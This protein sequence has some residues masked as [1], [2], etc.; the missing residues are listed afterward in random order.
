MVTEKHDL[1][2]LQCQQLY[3]K[4]ERCPRRLLC[5]HT[6][7]TS[8]LAHLIATQSCK[9]PTCSRPFLARTETQLP[10]DFTIYKRLSFSNNENVTAQLAPIRGIRN[11]EQLDSMSPKD[12]ETNDIPPHVNQKK[13]SGYS[14]AESDQSD[15]KS[16]SNL[17]SPKPF[18]HQLPLIGNTPSTDRSFKNTE[19]FAA[20]DVVDV[21]RQVIPA[22][23]ITQQDIQSIP[24][25]SPVMRPLTP[26]V[27]PRSFTSTLNSHEAQQL[28]KTKLSHYH[29]AK[30][31]T[32][33][34]LHEIPETSTMTSTP[35]PKFRSIEQIRKDLQDNKHRFPQNIPK[36]MKRSSITSESL[37]EP[38]NARAKP[39]MK[40]YARGM[41]L[42]EHS[43]ENESKGI[44]SHQNTYGTD[45]PD[46]AKLPDATKSK[47]HKDKVQQA[48]DSTL[49]KF[50]SNSNLT[51]V[52]S[53]SD[54]TVNK[55][56]PGIP[57]DQEHTN[58]STIPDHINGKYERP[59]ESKSASPSL[60]SG[61]GSLAGGEGKYSASLKPMSTS[62]PLYT[63]S[64]VTRHESLQ[65]T[66]GEQMTKKGLLKRQAP[67]PGVNGMGTPHSTP[68]SIKDKE[69]PS[70]TPKEANMYYYLQ[71]KSKRKAPSPYQDASGRQT[72]PPLA[73]K[74]QNS[75]PKLQSPVISAGIN[76]S[77]TKR[78]APVPD[79]LRIGEQKV[80][81]AMQTSLQSEVPKFLNHLSTLSNIQ[82][83]DVKK[84]Q[85]QYERRPPTPP[86]PSDMPASSSEDHSERKMNDISSTTAINSNIVENQ[87]KTSTQPVSDTHVEFKKGNG[88]EN[89]L[90]CK[91]EEKQNSVARIEG[92]Y[93]KEGHKNLYPSILTKECS[94]SPTHFTANSPVKGEKN[95]VD[96]MES[97]RALYLSKIHSG[98]LQIGSVSS[99]EDRPSEDL[100]REEP[101]VK[102]HEHLMKKHPKKENAEQNDC[103][104]GVIKSTVSVTEGHVSNRDTR[105]SR[106][107]NRSLAMPQSEAK[108][109]VKPPNSDTQSSKDSDSNMAADTKANEN[110]SQLQKS[111]TKGRYKSPYL[112]E[113]TSFRNQETLMTMPLSKSNDSY[114][115]EKKSTTDEDDNE[116]AQGSRRDYLNEPTLQ[117][118]TGNPNPKTL[119]ADNKAHKEKSE[120]SKI[121]ISDKNSNSNIPSEGSPAK[122]NEYS[123]YV[124]RKQANICIA[125]VLRHEHSVLSSDESV[126]DI[127]TEQESFSKLKH[128]T[129]DKKATLGKPQDNNPTAKYSYGNESCVPLIK[130]KQILVKSKNKDN[131]EVSSSECI[132]KYGYHKES[133]IPLIR[134]DPIKKD[135][136]SK[137]KN[138]QRENREKL[139]SK[140][141][142]KRERTN[143]LNP[144]SSQHKGRLTSHYKEQ[145]PSISENSEE[146][147]TD[148]T[149]SVSETESGDL[150]GSEK[151]CIQEYERK[152]EM[153]QGKSKSYPKVN[154][155]T[156]TSKIMKSFNYGN[157]IKGFKS[158]RAEAQVGKPKTKCKHTSDDRDV[159]DNGRKHRRAKTDTVFRKSRMT[160]QEM[161]C[162]T[163][164]EYEG[165]SQS[166][167]EVSPKIFRHKTSRISR[168]KS[169]DELLASRKDY[170]TEKSA[171][172]KLR[173]K[174]SVPRERKDSGGSKSSYY[175]EKKHKKMSPA[176]KS[177]ECSESESSDIDAKLQRARQRV[178]DAMN[179][180]IV[181]KRSHLPVKG[182]TMEK[183][184]NNRMKYNKYSSEDSTARSSR[185]LKRCVSDKER[186]RRQNQRMV[187][188]PLTAF[189]YD[190]RLPM[191]FYARKKE[192]E[193]TDQRLSSDR[194]ANKHSEKRKG[195]DQKS[196]YLLSDD[197]SHS[198][199]TSPLR[200][201]TL[202]INDDSDHIMPK[203]K[204]DTSPESH[205]KLSGYRTLHDDKSETS[206]DFPE[207]IYE[208][209]PSHTEERKTRNMSSSTLSSRTSRWD[210]SDQDQTN[211]FLLRRPLTLTDSQFTPSFNY[212]P[213]SQL[214]SANRTLINTEHENPENEIVTEKYKS[215][216]QPPQSKEVVKAGIGQ[217]KTHGFLLDLYCKT[218]EVWICNECL[219]LVHRPPPMGSCVAESAD[220]AVDNMKI[221]HAGLFD[222]KLATLDHFKSDLTRLLESCDNGIKEHETSIA[223]LSSRVLSEEMIIH[224]IKNM[225]SLVMQKWKQIDTW[226]DVLEA[227]ARRI[228]QSSSA[229]EMEEAV[230]KNHSAIVLNVMSGAASNDV[231]K[232]AINPSHIW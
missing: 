229:R 203:S 43:S 108:I 93:P 167:S 125:K 38:K 199:S 50:K 10:T 69:K 6:L 106:I 225:R 154:T 131:E 96:H 232:T 1:I 165:I 59:I 192:S 49:L 168:S 99:R 5:G 180:E 214:L 32:L 197:D 135:N 193:Y 78:R 126:P 67:I 170:K 95:S 71:V 23:V 48:Q 149:K 121:K 53:N 183:S 172:R 101:N 16:Y 132:T 11:A 24:P 123:Q 143:A 155:E 113:R 209:F 17:L 224:G 216:P 150:S 212:R 107:H 42:S 158:H 72:Y 169:S 104:K 227:N 86:S 90:T 148:V 196:R 179:D 204:I 188:L 2:C 160:A 55:I 223:Q 114:P 7:C 87:D 61:A 189:E 152:R 139:P 153:A 117:K 37:V 112:L 64:S 76:K 41:L 175:Y 18:K 208:A 100:Q 202:T 222:T 65:K 21:P 20:K 147:S 207:D 75:V 191:R 91:S 110:S 66:L 226:E 162:S 190:E 217:C 138:Q 26:S 80:S 54:N 230:Q 201:T 88:E 109:C 25:P 182:K 166:D 151:A 14:K 56:K 40:T 98:E 36:P 128:N 210:E 118:V 187:D 15:S 51:H 63:I 94:K 60:T 58:I 12:Q 206:E 185:K 130:Y 115:N 194:R 31:S 9:C 146:F 52:V 4:K 79:P 81:I 89:N 28:P 184:K 129:S 178:R 35:I 159:S 142:D 124:T 119:D 145:N 195:K 156:H 157:D 215:K 137:S 19:G 34:T 127:A 171:T 30:V 83:P 231:S 62:S 163:L 161:G 219:D 47:A 57:T 228:D 141:S 111:R 198:T 39:S 211:G 218:C 105:A 77:N 134:Y 74:S 174:S 144:I 84:A 173:G 103:P 8:C 102:E 13:V 73:N 120:R 181:T 22:N 97:S 46:H 92:N 177:A 176:S 140:N 44:S 200:L 164:S 27:S 116:I 29:P 220:Q 70:S 122:G 213:S 136:S 82:H 133:C 68:P 221:C 45:D 85:I 205:P 33:P 3:T 186:L